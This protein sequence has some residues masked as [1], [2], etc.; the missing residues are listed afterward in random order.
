MITVEQANKMEMLLGRY[1]VNDRSVTMRELESFIGH[2]RPN[3]FKTGK[4]IGFNSYLNYMFDDWHLTKEKIM[5]AFKHILQTE[6]PV[7]P[8]VKLGFFGGGGQ[9]A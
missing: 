9:D 7:E 3:S 5:H 2:L 8:E 1:Y 4:P 6:K